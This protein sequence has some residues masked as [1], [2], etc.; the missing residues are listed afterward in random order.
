MLGH[1]WKQK[2]LHKICIVWLEL[3]TDAISMSEVRSDRALVHV[4]ICRKDLQ[5]DPYTSSLLGKSSPKD[6]LVSPI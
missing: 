5:G 1:I 4:N 2:H 6:L 3:H